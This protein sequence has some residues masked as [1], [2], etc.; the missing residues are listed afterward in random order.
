M[1]LKAKRFECLQKKKKADGERVVE[2]DRR[3]DVSPNPKTPKKLRAVCL[4]E[5]YA[6]YA[7]Y[8]LSMKLA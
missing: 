3:Q 4:C 8:G 7:E 2:H 5:M 1:K 6:V